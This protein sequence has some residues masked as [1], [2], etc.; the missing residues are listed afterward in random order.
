LAPA[1]QVS[2]I[3]LN[4]SLKE[5]GRGSS[6]G[7]RHN[8]LRG[9]LVVAEVSLAF[10]LLIG[11]GL[12]M[13]TF[14]YLQRV[15]PGF[16]SANV[17]TATVD[18]PGARYPTWRK[19]SAFYHDLIARVAALPGVEEAGVTSDLPW[20]GYDENTSFGIEGRQ[21]SD[22]ESPSA[23]YHFASSDYF[24][25]VGIPLVAG[26][27]FSESDD[28]DAP[29]VILINKS[30]ADRYWP[31][32]DAVGKRV[33]LWGETR[34][35]TGIVGDL[36]DS[37]GELRA[38]PGFFYPVSQQVQSGLVL[39]IRT[40]GDPMN[41][42]ATTRNEIAALDKDLP[43]SDI[44]TLDQVSIAAL[45][46]TRFTMLLLSVFAGVALLLAAVGIYGVMSYSV[47]Q[48]THE[49][50]IRV[51]LGAQQRD[52]ISLVARQGLTLAL[53][54]LGAGMAAALALTRVMSSLLFG[55]GA[56][57]P[58]TFAGIA[59][60]LIGVA[61]GACFVPARRAT[62]MDPMIALRHE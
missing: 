44:K 42:I 34:T 52:V 33:R 60:L 8:R 59:V 61:L 47:T 4:E 5:G 54:G 40:Q 62:K 37:P 31:D 30:M 50:G 16:K 11:A 7:S 28:A 15:D 46:R 17:L 49:I 38:K 29:K 36:K 58:I 12:L 51:A 32:E 27:F 6:G 21:F 57:D 1:L 43:L 26:R 9:L 22:D 56:A 24:R 13:R 45:A 53:A 35:I 2:K 39:V 48:R 3:N 10:V 41:L 14:F 23:Q 18:L 55:V 25:A 19:A 20:T